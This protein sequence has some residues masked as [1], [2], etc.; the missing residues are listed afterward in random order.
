[1]DR[2]VRSCRPPGRALDPGYTATDLHGHRGTQP[3]AEGA[4]I[5]VR[6]ASLGT[7]GPTG[8]FFDRTG[9]VVW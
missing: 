1:V 2:A 5:L 7:D 3:V 6:M 8:G 4:E 9:P